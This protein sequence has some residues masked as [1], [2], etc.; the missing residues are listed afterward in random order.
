MRTVIFVLV[1]TT[2]SSDHNLLHLH[3]AAIDEAKHVN[4]WNNIMMLLVATTEVFTADETSR[5]I[6]NL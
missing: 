6:N 4:T 5:D 1:R 3:V 2:L